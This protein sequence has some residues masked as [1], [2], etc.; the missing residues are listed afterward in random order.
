MSNQIKG[1]LTIAI[2]LMI[3]WG[4]GGIFQGSGFIGGIGNQIDAIGSII[5]LLMKA[6]L[7]LGVIW[8]F[9]EIFKDKEANNNSTL[10]DN[11][12][13]LIKNNNNSVGKNKF[14]NKEDDDDDDDDYDDDD[15]DDENLKLKTQL[16]IETSPVLGAIGTP[17]ND[18]EIFKIKYTN[19]AEDPFTEEN[20]DEYAIV[21]FRAFS[22]YEFE[23]AIEAFVE[24]D[25]HIPKHKLMSM[26][27]PLNLAEKLNPRMKGALLLHYI[28]D[29]EN[30][31]F[32]VP[33]KFTPNPYFEP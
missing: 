23:Q 1:Y 5:S 14:N 20:G 9:I 21:T 7:V 10:I 19:Y 3:I 26:K 15:D 12:S 28:F 8:L 31:E 16:L 27:M 6:A 22:E 25:Y 4:I 11:N 17:Y 13:N 18:I 32:V 2:F 33:E 24:E 30:N 29:S